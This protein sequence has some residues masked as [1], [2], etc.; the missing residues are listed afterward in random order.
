MSTTY[1]GPPHG[2]DTPCGT[3]G[4]EPG[5]DRRRHRSVAAFTAL[6]ISVLGFLLAWRPSLAVAALFLLT[7]GFTVG[8]VALFLRGRKWPAISAI[9]VSVV[10]VVVTVVVF[11]LAAGAA[12]IRSWDSQVP[13]SGEGPGS[14]PGASAPL[15]E[16]SGDGIGDTRGRPLPL[17]ATAESPNWAVTL[18][19]V[20][21][22]ATAEIAAV[23]PDIT[24]RLTEKFV[25]ADVTLTYRGTDT[26]GG[27]VL[28][29]IAYVFPDG[30][31][32]KAFD[33]TATT[34]TPLPLGERVPPGESRSGSAAI[35]VPY[36]PGADGVIAIQPDPT[37]PATFF[38]AQ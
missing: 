38:A 18:N 15:L 17:G 31:Y 11:A 16:S 14:T 22:D 27:E 35:L 4:A 30:T 6:G 34:P 21:L 7:A 33:T 36:A 3:A 29:V 2:V 23:N 20:D 9:V 5:T 28:P 10:G 19:R 12:L 25:L 32:T 37:T 13:P 26:E 24:P 1:T 8:I